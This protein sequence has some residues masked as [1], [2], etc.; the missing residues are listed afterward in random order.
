M[1]YRVI[2]GGQCLASYKS[3]RSAKAAY[4]LIDAAFRLAKV[5]LST[6]DFCLNLVKE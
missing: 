1:I 2:L 4:N 6:F 3:L 5:D